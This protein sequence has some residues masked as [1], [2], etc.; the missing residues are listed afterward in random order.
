MIPPT[1]PP[2]SDDVDCK[3]SSTTTVD[4][5]LSRAL[6]TWASALFCSRDC[7]SQ[8]L[9]KAPC[10]EQRSPRATSPAASPAHGSFHLTPP[11][12][13]LLSGLL[14]FGVSL[15]SQTLASTG[16]PFPL[17]SDRGAAGLKDPL[18]SFQQFLKS[19]LPC[20][21]VSL[22]SALPLGQGGLC[23]HFLI[24]GRKSASEP[25]ILTEDGVPVGVCGLL[26][27]ELLLFILK[28]SVNYVRAC[29]VHIMP[30]YK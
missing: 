17:A 21:G 20:T 1:V 4:G 5:L 6:Q 30:L 10:E 25:T 27:H 23:H 24:R 3:L 22:G 13:W 12:I 8:T 18:F 28:Y 15:L 19:L 9:R 29:Q 7:S 11:H 2:A 26:R 14:L 16:A